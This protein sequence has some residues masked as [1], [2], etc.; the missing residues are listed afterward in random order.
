MHAPI[1]AARETELGRET[2]TLQAGSLPPQD[3]VTDTKGGREGK[4]KGERQ[5][6]R[7]RQSQRQTETE[8]ER[9]VSDVFYHRFGNG[10]PGH[11][12]RAPP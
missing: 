11:N 8:T 4:G 7:Q 9:N 6:Q 12:S 1:G 10:I 5:R 2:N 3:R